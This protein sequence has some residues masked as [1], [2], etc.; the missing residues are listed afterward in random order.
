MHIHFR[1]SVSF[2]SLWAG[3]LALFMAALCQFNSDGAQPTEINLSNYVRVARYNLPEPTRTTPPNSTNLLCQE[4]S[5]VA[6]NSDTDNLFIVGDGA[7]SVTQVSKTGVLIDTMTLAPGAFTDPEGITYIGGGQFVFSE[8]RDRQLVKFTYAAGTVLTRANTRTVKIGTTIS[9]IGIEGLSWDPFTGG[10]ICVKES[11][12]I[13]V[14]QTLVDFDAGT[15][16]NG[17]PTTQNSTNLFNPSLLGVTDLADVFALANLPSLTNHP[18]NDHLLLISQENAR[19]LEVDRAGAIYSTLTIVSDPGNPLSAADQQHEGLTMDRDGILYVVSEN[20]GGDINH[21]Q[22]WVYAPSTPT[23]QPPAQVLTIEVVA[24]DAVLYW[25]AEAIGY[26]LECTS[27]LELAGSW[28]NV[29]QSVV[30]TNGLNRVTVPILEQQ[31]F[32][33][34][35]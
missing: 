20:G 11:S 15:A 8:E 2:S 19:I 33:L 29:P 5:G 23:N 14:F 27:T 32:R 13:G 35:R 25:P 10:F 22:L 17:S 30:L 18:D 26:R 9:N 16:S 34:R 1:T 3:T 6:Y 31:F 21:P 12:P 28:T 24:N 4:A 7:R